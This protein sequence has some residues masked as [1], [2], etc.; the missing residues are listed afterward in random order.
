[1]EAAMTRVFGDLGVVGIT[2]VVSDSGVENWQSPWPAQ[3][4][5]REGVTSVNFSAN[6]IDG[7]VRGRLILNFPLR[8]SWI[9]ALPLPFSLSR[10]ENSDL[11]STTICVVYEER[12][13]RVVHVHEFVGDGTGLFGKDGEEERW[14]MALE[15]ARHHTDSSHLQTLDSE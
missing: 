1:M 8:W 5:Y 12:D 15:T 6:V 14:R 9:Q 2:Q 11:I 7:G 4:V 3:A 10:P 13:G